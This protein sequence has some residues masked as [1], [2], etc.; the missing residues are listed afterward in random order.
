MATDSAQASRRKCYRDPAIAL[1]ALAPTFKDAEAR[2]ELHVI[3]ADYELL[4]KYAERLRA[5]NGPVSRWR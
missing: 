2:K 1:R 3:A 4:A 5:F